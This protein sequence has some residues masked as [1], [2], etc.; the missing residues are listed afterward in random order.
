MSDT[1][2]KGLAA[3]KRYQ[4]EQKEKAEAANRPKADWFKWP[5]GVSVATVLFLQEMDEGAAG[6]KEDRGLGFIV[7]EHQAPGPDG[8]KRRANCTIES[9]GECYACER[10]SQDYKEGWRQRTNLYINAL[11]DFNNGEGP[12]PVVI[13]RNANSSF[14]QALIEEAVEENTITAANYRITKVGEGTTTQWLLKGLKDRFDDEKVEVFDLE[15]TAIRV[16]PYEKQADYYGAVYSGPAESAAAPSNA[17]SA[18]VDAD[19]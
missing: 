8:F 16:V 15:E 1:T 4:Q 6:Y 11:V 17:G 10:H 5:K 14:V 13:S 9:E 19:W 12:K 2:L 18:S 7:V 3:I